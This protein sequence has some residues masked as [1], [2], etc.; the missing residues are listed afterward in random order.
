MAHKEHRACDT[1]RDQT[2]EEVRDGRRH[3]TL[4]FINVAVNSSRTRLPIRNADEGRSIRAHVMRDYLRKNT[5]SLKSRDKSPA[6]TKL[7]D[8][9]IQFRLNSR[10]D[11]KRSR[12]GNNESTS[13]EHTSSSVPAR[14]RL[15]AILPKND[16]S[17]R[18]AVLAR[19]LANDLLCNISLPIKSS[20]PGTSALLEYYHT[21]FWDNSLAVNPEGSW[22]S[23]AISDSA[24][25]H[26]TLCLVA[27]H[28]SQT[29]GESLANSYFWHRGEA[30]RLISKNLADP[31][32][33]ISDA[34]IG[35]VAVLSASDNS[36]SLSTFIPNSTVA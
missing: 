1:T 14:K 13:D 36:V 6:V 22:I 16:Q 18:G 2:S 23:V 34:T 15:S 24:M 9:L 35:A 30:M 28:K 5:K 25:L 3:S 29:A 26:A 12:R 33:A 8:H 19:S 11:R 21:S 32:H 20:T 4:R 10:R 7:S 27:L 17:L 31:S